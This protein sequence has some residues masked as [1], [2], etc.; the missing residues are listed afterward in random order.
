MAANSNTIKETGCPSLWMAKK[1][2][3][4][5]LERQG[6]KWGSQEENQITKLSE[7]YMWKKAVLAWSYD[8][9]GSTMHSTPSTRLGGSKL[10]ERTWSTVSE[11][12]RCCQ[13]GPTK[14]GTYLRRSWGGSS[15]ETRVVSK[16]CPMRLYGCGMNLGQGQG[17]VTFNS[18]W[19]GDP[20]HI[21]GHFPLP[22]YTVIVVKQIAAWVRLRYVCLWIWIIFIKCMTTKVQSLC[23]KWKL[24]LSRWQWTICSPQLTR[25]RHLH[26][27]NTALWKTSSWYFFIITVCY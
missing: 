18:V 13:E 21:V 14:N 11:L 12:E 23:R 22:L 27:Q 24:T 1:Y 19:L 17:Q 5:I 10:Q 20:Q 7:H 8:K 4:H 6:N 3:R 9:N 26:F 25:E 15:W 16:C 2:T